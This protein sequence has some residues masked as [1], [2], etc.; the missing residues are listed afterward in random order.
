M[1]AS[2]VTRRIVELGTYTP[3][4]VNTIA[5]VP[6]QVVDIMKIIFVYTTANSGAGS[7]ITMQRRPVADSA[8]NQVS[9]GTFKTTAVIAAGAVEVFQTSKPFDTDGEVAED[10][11]T[12]YTAAP[13]LEGTPPAY[14]ATYNRIYP[15]Q[16]FALVS[17]GEGTAG[18]VDVFLD[19]VEHGFHEA[20]IEANGGAAVTELAR[21]S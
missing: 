5:Y 11:T 8:A 12:R 1:S 17:A 14:T 20:D 16:D 21:V 3:S 19:V 18:V 6:G 10:G 4:G 15:G 13:Y 7:V 2:R 9:L